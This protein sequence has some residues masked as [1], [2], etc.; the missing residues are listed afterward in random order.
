MSFRGGETL[1]TL[2]Q[3]KPFVLMLSPREMS[4][5]LGRATRVDLPWGFLE[6]IPAFLRQRGD[7][8]K[9]GGMHSNDG[10]P[11]TLDEYLKSASKTDVARWLAAVLLAVRVVDVR[12]R[13]ALSIRLGTGK[14]Y[15]PPETKPV[16]SSPTCPH[17]MAA[18]DCAF[19]SGRFR[20]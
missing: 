18:S 5:I 12:L 3:A 2:G 10:E 17:G 6:T 7:W 19:C 13:P 1:R 9:V 15:A 4:L 14:T 16:F 11:G 8:V 20:R